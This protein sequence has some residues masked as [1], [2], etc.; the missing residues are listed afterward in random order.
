M[1]YVN[2]Y[3]QIGFIHAL[4]TKYEKFNTAEDQCNLFDDADYQIK[5]EYTNNN[6][7]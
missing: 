5:K 4:N 3:D 2:D 7:Q 1:D 6:Q